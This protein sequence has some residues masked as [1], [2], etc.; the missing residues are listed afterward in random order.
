MSYS[1]PPI[2]LCLL[3]V[4]SISGGFWK[5][6]FL[7][8]IKHFDVWSHCSTSYFTSLVLVSP[9]VKC[10]VCIPQS[11]RFRFYTTVSCWVLYS[12]PRTS[13]IFKKWVVSVN[14]MQLIACFIGATQ[15]AGVVLHFVASIFWLKTLLQYKPDKIKNGKTGTEVGNF[16]F[17]IRKKKKPSSDF[18]ANKESG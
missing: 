5:R 13:L 2:F 9:A 14:K 7:W 15:L 6:V 1:E 8:S 12:Y 4:G 16:F 3:L 17:N 18:L 10:S 11:Q